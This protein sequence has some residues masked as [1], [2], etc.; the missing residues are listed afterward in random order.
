MG[1]KDQ[2]PEKVDK[3]EAAFRKLD[4]NNDGF[5]DWSEFKKVYLKSNLL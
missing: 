3:I 5:I 4:I 2:R 1:R